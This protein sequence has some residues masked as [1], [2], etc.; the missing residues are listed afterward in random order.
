MADAIAFLVIM[1][2]VVITSFTLG[3]RSVR[4]PEIRQTD[5]VIVVKHDTTLVDSPVPVYVE[6]VRT[7][8]LAV[9]DTIVRNDTTFI[10][11]PIERKVYEDSTYKAVVSGYMA[12]LDSLWIYRATK[13]VTVTNT[14]KE[15]RKKIGFS[16]GVGPAVIYSPFTSSLD[17]G[18]GVFGGLT[19][20]F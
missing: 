1:S 18:V 17:A 3:R 16:V 7:E 2:V 14:V 10:P 4:G 11:V 6:R 20:T 15:P 13:Y 5:T 12:S 9:T 8:Y 19:W